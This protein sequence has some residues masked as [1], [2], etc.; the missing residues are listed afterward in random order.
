MSLTDVIT[1]PIIS[2]VTHHPIVDGNDYNFTNANIS[3]LWSIMHDQAT[4]GLITIDSSLKESYVKITHGQLDV[5]GNLV[6]SGNSIYKLVSALEGKI[7]L[8][9]HDGIVSGFDLQAITSNLMKQN[10]LEGIVNL[11]S[12]S[13]KKGETPFSSLEGLIDIQQGIAHIKKLKLSIK[14][15]E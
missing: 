1:D 14:F 3:H 6:T 4:C 7:T 10:R 8:D 11:L 5:N 13:F 15:R 12:A 2:D 9:A